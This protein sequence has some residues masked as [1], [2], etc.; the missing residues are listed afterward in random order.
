MFGTDREAVPPDDVKEKEE[1]EEEE[2][3]DAA[4]AP[5]AADGA[6]GNDDDET[7]YRSCGCVLR[8]HVS[9]PTERP[10]IRLIT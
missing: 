2:E 5:A 3:E 6:G 10:R 8:V 4:G 1:E 7:E 9:T